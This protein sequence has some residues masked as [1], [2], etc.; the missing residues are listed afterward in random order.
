MFL[1]FAILFSLFL[2]AFFPSTAQTP[3]AIERE[4]IVHLADISRFGNYGGGYDGDKL[5][6]AN[7]ALRQKLMRFGTRADVLAYGFT[8]L[9]DEMYVATSKDGRLRIYSWDMQTGGTM[10]D[11]AAVFQFKGKSGKVITRAE[12]DED[13]S[14]GSFYPEIFQVSSRQGP[15]YLATSTFIGS[16]SMHGQSIKVI[17]INGDELD[18]SAKLIRTAEGLTNSVGFGYDFFSVVDRPERPIKLFE[19]NEERKEFRFPVV[20]EDEKTPQGR[21]TDRFITY[22]F[23]GRYFIKVK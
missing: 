19:F 22:R 21:V 15:V 20:I 8:G 10:R 2:L 16:T 4:L 17:R 9:N 18:L 12:N 5:S 1:R 6:A 11:F 23:N 7:D 13:E 14:A 3:E